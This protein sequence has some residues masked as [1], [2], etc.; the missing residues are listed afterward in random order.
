MPN[1]TRI[2]KTDL[3]LIAALLLLAGVL[4]A[5]G[6]SGE[7][8]TAAV[9]VD[10]KLLY[11]I[12]LD[13]VKEPYTLTLENGVTLAVEPGSIRFAASDCRGQDCVKCGALRRAGQAAACVPNKTVITVSGKPDKNAPDALSW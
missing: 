13:G 7:S 12:P 2:K 1:R 6:R 5:L 9:T 3:I 10:G 8:P 4:F 11:S